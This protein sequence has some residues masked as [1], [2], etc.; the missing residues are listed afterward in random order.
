MGCRVLGVEIEK[1]RHDASLDLRLALY[2]VLSTVG[3]TNLIPPSIPSF[4][5]VLQLFLLIPLN[6]LLIFRPITR[7]INATAYSYIVSIDS[8][9]QQKVTNALNNI[10]LRL[11][12]ITTLFHGPQTRPHIGEFTH[13]WFNNAYVWFDSHDGEN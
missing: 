13:Y 7:T 9:F 3:G 8:K 5:L 6:T 11:A 1:K 10:G 12:C 2:N 4:H